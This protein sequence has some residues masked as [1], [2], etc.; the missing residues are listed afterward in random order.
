MPLWVRTPKEPPQAAAQEPGLHQGLPAHPAARDQMTC[1]ERH[2]KDLIREDRDL[3]C[4]VGDVGACSPTPHTSEIHRP[5]SPTPRHTGTHIHPRV[6]HHTE[7]HAC[8]HTPYSVNSRPPQP[9]LPKL[10]PTGLEG[11]AVPT[12]HHIPYPAQSRHSPKPGTDILSA[13]LRVH[14]WLPLTPFPPGPLARRAA[15]RLVVST[16]V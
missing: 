9:P 15:F 2:S 13:A 7:E 11:T 3:E 1:A 14:P 4:A 6:T 8:A 10:A 12:T 5:V 16:R